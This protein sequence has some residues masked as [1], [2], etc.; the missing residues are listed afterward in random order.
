MKKLVIIILLVGGISSFV[1]YKGIIPDNFRLF[2][3]DKLISKLEIDRYLPKIKL[4]LDESIMKKLSSLKSYIAGK[5]A[6]MNIAGPVTADTVTLYLKNGST[7]SGE[8]VMESKDAYTIL[9]KDG[10][11]A[12]YKDEIDRVERGVRVSDAKGM[13]F[14]EGVAEEW[15]YEHD[16]AIVLTNGMI[17]DADIAGVDKEKITIEYPVE[18]GNISQ[19]IERSRVEYLL[20]K[21]IEN[22]K[23]KKIEKH[24]KELFPKMRFYRE[25]NFTIITDSYITWVRRYRA[26]LRRTYSDIYIKFFSLFKDGEPQLQNFV[27][28]FDD[29]IDFVEY[30]VSDGVPGWAVLGYFN[31]DDRA[32]YL[33]NVL[34]DRFSDFL[35]ESFIG[36]PGEAIDDAADR[37]KTMAGDRYEIVIQGLADD[38]KDKFWRYYNMIK[39][40]F[41]EMTFGTLRH[42]FAHEVFSNWGFQNI[43]VSRSKQD[44]EKLQKKKKDFLDT[45]DKAK[46]KKLLMELLTLKS[47]KG[48]VDL[49]AANS[50]LAEGAATYC[51]TDPIGGKNDRW[52][53]TFQKMK[54]ENAIYPLEHLTVY[55]I[56]SFPGVYPEAMLY[57]YAQSWAFFTFLM[58]R[59]PA[60]FMEYQR[61]FSR[62]KAEE[63]EDIEW[64]VEALGKDIRIIEKEF[65]EYMDRLEKLEDP[66]IE[67]FE[68]WSTI[69]R[70]FG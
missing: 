49:K 1:L 21:P 37:L 8:L 19:D 62:E 2:D 67:R 54:R 27:V 57:A 18:G 7:I 47:E 66:L 6:K 10:E 40:E 42:E 34:G 17:L 20:F 16:M 39:N 65:V 48:T 30:A 29:Y 68:K 28:V 9:W 38:V 41:S 46:K 56:G 63:H 69:F 36:K 35:F 26:T 43:V 5:T 59:Y 50:W 60:Q 11:V 53:F 52:L 64:L 45:K 70:E 24:L 4:F 31:P 3:K 22:N 15:P 12:F 14:D 13:L 25:G 51:E 55:K 44:R 61:R 32:L 58:D 23:T 33:F